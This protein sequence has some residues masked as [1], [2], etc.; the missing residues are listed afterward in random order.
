M[1]LDWNI[2]KRSICSEISEQENLLLQQW[3]SKDSKHTELY[4]DAQNFYAKDNHNIKF[5][6]EDI[7]LQWRKLEHSKKYA[8]KRRFIRTATVAA[9]IIIILSTSLLFNYLNRNIDSVATLV[10]VVET[11]DN[12]H[13]LF[14]LEDGD[15]F[16]IENNSTITIS[17][18]GIVEQHSKSNQKKIIK[19]QAS[20][21][22]NN[23]QLA[24]VTSPSNDIFFMTLS[25]GTKVWMNSNTKLKFPLQ[26]TGATRVVHIQGEAYFE[27]VHNDKKP[28]IVRS[29]D[30]EVLVLGTKFNVNSYKNT[31]FE[32]T[33]IEGSVK[34]G[35]KSGSNVI[36]RPNE[37][38]TIIDGKSGVTV[39]EVDVDIILSWKQERLIFND[40]KLEYILNRIGNMYGYTIEFVD[41]SARDERFMFYTSRD[42]TIED[43]MDIISRSKKVRFEIEDKIIK[44]Y[45]L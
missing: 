22:V 7:D 21:L 40:D 17:N 18:K 26:F 29:K 43:V 6:E 23:I 35:D 45:K 15:S 42:I 33:L 12:D 5:T 20:K 8:R 14:E 3:I 31:L 34:V 38:G 30:K 41:D 28:F 1:E 44:V 39:S 19:K 37:K 27:V 24:S 4:R 16:K 2:I 32:T 9:S 25:D 36:L 13:V 10:P 11:V